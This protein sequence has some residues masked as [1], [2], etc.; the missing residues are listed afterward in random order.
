M[1]GFLIVLAAAFVALISTRSKEPEEV[2]NII[3]RYGGKK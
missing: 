2:E 1:T 3:Q